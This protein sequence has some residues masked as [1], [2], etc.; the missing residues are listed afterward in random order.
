MANH[1]TVGGSD[2]PRTVLYKRY[3]AGGKVAVP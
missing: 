1:G 2:Q 3:M